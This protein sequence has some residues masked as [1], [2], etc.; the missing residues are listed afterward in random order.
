MMRITAHFVVILIVKYLSNNFV[1]AIDHPE[2]FV[3]LLAGMI[4]F[5]PTFAAKADK[6]WRS[7][8]T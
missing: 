4:P 5:Y 8:F 3:N 6:A 7:Y 2:D 1:V